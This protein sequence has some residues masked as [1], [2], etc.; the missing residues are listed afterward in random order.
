MTLLLQAMPGIS[1]VKDCLFKLYSI[2]VP[3][4]ATV[5]ASLI[6]QL[7]S[8]PVYDNVLD[9][10]LALRKWKKLLG[11]ASEMGVSLPDGSVLLAAVEAAIKRVVEGTV[12]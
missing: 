6:R 10:T 2:Y 9:V 8:I 11:R 12:T 3:G 1:K 5:R 4:G 7:E